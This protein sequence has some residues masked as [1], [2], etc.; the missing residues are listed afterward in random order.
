MVHRNGNGRYGRRV[1]PNGPRRRQHGRGSP[2]RGLLIFGSILGLGLMV[3]SLI[4]TLATLQATT[5]AYAAFSADLP[6]VNGVED[7]NTFKTVSIYDRNGILLWEFWEPS[8]GMRTPVP[9]NEISQNLIDATLAAED[10]YFYT[11]PGVELKGILRALVQNSSGG[12][13][14]SG[15][16][17]ITQQLARNVLLSPD[18]KYERS[19]SRK[20]KE[21]LLAYRLTQNFPKDRILELYLNEIYY[22]NMSYGVE[23]AAQSYFGKHARDLTLAEAAVIA[24]LPQAPS[25]YDP[26]HNAQAALDRRA[27]V[28]DQMARHGFIS[29][30]EAELAKREPLKLSAQKVEM[31]APHWVNFI[32]DQLEQRYGPDVVYRSGLKVFT[33]LDLGLTEQLQQVALNNRDYL[34]T[35]DGSNTAITALNPKTGE[36]LA[37][38]GSM[39]YWDRDIDGQV[40]VLL[41]ERQ[42]GSTLKP[43]VYMLSFL[44]GWNPATTIMDTLSCW[45][46][47]AGYRWC[48]VNYDL[49]F[50][51][52]VTVRAALGNSMNIPAVKTLEYVGV[53]TVKDYARRFGITTWDDKKNVGLSLT[54]G[55]AEVK[56]L[57]LAG[58]YASLAN[59]GLRIPLVGIT[60]IVDAKGN[61]LEDY[62]VPPGTQIVD[63]RAAYMI[64][65]ILTDNQARLITFGPNSLINMP[66]P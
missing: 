5:A 30:R 60:R 40:N 64:T 26:Y 21:A 34:A 45:T 12:G 50:R 14:V 2:L 9:L 4:V 15:A 58:F 46:N 22:G 7:R 36:I 1:G 28:L 23:A 6:P 65:H 57:E 43:L 35:K 24:G 63:P 20:L 18:E 19:I 66:R 13:V 33:T 52:P 11:N 27:Y 39:D 54:L 55:G 8:A 62:K 3:V 29:E 32:R 59:N 42:P 37:M 38:V 49:T 48:P 53:D 16:S 41:S 56:P 44:K 10:A 25:A 61:V 17:T 51:G 31:K 47:V